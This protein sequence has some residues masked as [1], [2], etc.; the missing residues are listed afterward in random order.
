MDKRKYY[1]KRKNLYEIP[2]MLDILEKIS[3]V[4]W[5]IRASDVRWFVLNLIEKEKVE[6]K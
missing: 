5:Y 3:P 6:T 4:C 2:E 1:I